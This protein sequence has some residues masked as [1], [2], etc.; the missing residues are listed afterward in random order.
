MTRKR[1]GRRLND[2]EEQVHA[3]TPDADVSIELTDTDREHIDEIAADTPTDC[4]A[5]AAA[6]V[7]AD[8]SDATGAHGLTDAER[9]FF[10]VLCEEAGA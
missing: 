3:D 6:R 4:L 5:D 10:N 2:L 9:E 7:N 1:L 8:E